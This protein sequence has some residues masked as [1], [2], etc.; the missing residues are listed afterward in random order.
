MT[1]FI[2]DI[3]LGVTP[4]LIFLFLLRLGPFFIPVSSAL[5]V[6]LGYTALFLLVTT[7]MGLPLPDALTVP[8]TAG[9]IGFLLL[10]F[11]RPKEK[12]VEVMKS[13]T[14][15]THRSTEKRE[16][17]ATRQEE[18]FEVTPSD[19]PPSTSAPDRPSPSDTPSV[20]DPPP[21]PDRPQQ[22]FWDPV[23]ERDRANRFRHLTLSLVILA[24]VACGVGLFIWIWSSMFFEDRPP[25]TG[26]SA[27]AGEVVEKNPSDPASLV[28]GKDGSVYLGGNV[29][30]EFRWIDS[31]GLWIGRFEVTNEEYRRFRPNHASRESRGM[32]LNSE[33]QPV[34]W[35]S[36]DE[37]RAFAAWMRR[38]PDLQAI[39]AQVRLPTGGEW[40]EMARCGTDRAFPWG[41][42]W[43]PTRGNYSDQ[44]AAE[45][46]GLDGITDYDDGFAVSAPVDSSGA[47]EW[48]LHGVGGNVWEWTSEQENSFRIIRGGSWLSNQSDGLRVDDR[49]RVLPDRSHN[50][51]GFRLVIE[52]TL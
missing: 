27:Q 17:W 22:N 5:V 3:I 26:T 36:H 7:L 1:A 20:S 10:Y 37:A 9:V 49:R 33:R 16:V 48:G 4:L 41:D 13:A 50:D 8:L 29:H 44:T 19:P 35:V 38:R 18:E 42:A 24:V 46:L 15:E 21:S 31:L 43:P 39:N 45:E 40:T 47:N 51:L 23:P 25:S 32:T 12:T 52:P 14:V 2:V 34:V 11:F 6:S 30:M 28:V